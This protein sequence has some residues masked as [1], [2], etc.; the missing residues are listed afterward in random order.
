MFDD[1]R[2]K[3]KRSPFD[4]IFE[5]MQRMMEEFEKHFFEDFEELTKFTPKFRTPSGMEVR[6]PIVWGWSMTI[7]PDGKPIIREFGNVPKKEMMKEV[8]D[9]EGAAFGPVREPLIDIIDTDDEI[10]VVA[11]VPG[12][13][14]DEIDIEAEGKT[15]IIKAS[16]KYYKE[17]E[18]P[19]EVIPEKAKANYKNGILEVKLPKAKKSEPKKKIKVE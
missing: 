8:P 19:T 2:K 17:L 5:E 16:D 11:E 14:K 4:D 18:L 7:G 3:R 10:T 9:K 1:W 6:G 12:V 13:E 15:L